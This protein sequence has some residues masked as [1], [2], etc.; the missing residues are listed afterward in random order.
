[1]KKKIVLMSLMIAALVSV[2][3]ISAFAEDIV[4]SKT[5]SEEYGTIIQLNA[6]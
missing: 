5:E 4:V 3:A 1:M 2:F 6:M